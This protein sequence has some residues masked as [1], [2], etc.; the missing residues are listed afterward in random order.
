LL[1]DNTVLEVAVLVEV[2]MDRGLGGCEFLQSLYVPEPGHRS[3]SSSER[4]VGILGSIV[5]PAT[6]LLTICDT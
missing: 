6:A 4:L 2:V 3:F 5:E 1:E